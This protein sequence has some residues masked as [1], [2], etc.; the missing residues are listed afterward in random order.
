MR[1]VRRAAV[2]LGAV[3]IAFPLYGAN[4]KLIS[5]LL[6]NAYK[7]QIV[8]LRTFYDGSTLR[9]SSDG[10]F[11]EGGKPGPWT[12]DASLR[13]QN[14]HLGSKEL[15][16]TGKRI[17]YVYDPR[18]KKLVPFLGSP[19]TVEIASGPATVS[20]AN[21]QTAIAKV[22]LTGK[23][24][25]TDFVPDYW[26]PYLLHPAMAPE[27]LD[28]IFNDKVPGLY[29]VGNG[30]TAP[31]VIRNPQPTQP[32]YTEAARNAKVQGVIMLGM[33][34]GTDGRVGSIVVLQPLGLGTDEGAVRAV[35]AWK[36]TPALW[37][38]HP[39]PVRLEVDVTFRLVH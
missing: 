14:V 3:A 20:I 2:L 6:D 17:W 1:I 26:K 33:T 34:I 31:K 9:Y 28:T 23:E 25:F 36:F 27:R 10:S 29:K 30:V 11:I 12:L 24:R 5:S 19:V 15:L 22:I 13:I 18:R 38:G 37:D 16:I 39:V 35:R 4:L 8:T 21:L 32:Q 7:N